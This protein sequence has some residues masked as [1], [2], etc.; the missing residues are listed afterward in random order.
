MIDIK[1][2]LWFS[3]D[4]HFGHRN[5]TLGVSTWKDKETNCRHFDTTE[6]MSN[7]I[8]SQINKYVKEDDTL[9]NLGDWSFGGM[10]N[11][12][13]YRKQLLCKNIYLFLGNHD[14]HIKNNKVLINDDISRIDAQSLFKKVFKYEE[15]ILDKIR[16]CLMHFPIEEWNDRYEKSYML[17]GHQHGN[18]VEKKGRLDVG[19]DNAFKL[20]GEYRPFSWEEI[21]LILK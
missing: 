16:V 10:Q 19:I 5:M 14:E 6:E 8:V 18:N 11:I 4:F 15:I 13:Y 2:N 21:K 17:H 7:H 12:L 3:S 9:I 20:F 1:N